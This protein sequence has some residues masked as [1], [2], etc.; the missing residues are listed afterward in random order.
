MPEG[1]EQPG[2]GRRRRRRRGG[3]GRRRGG[4]GRQQI[5]RVPLEPINLGE[6]LQSAPLSTYCRDCGAEVQGVL[7]GT[8]MQCPNCQGFNTAFGTELSVRNYFRL[9]ARPVKPRYD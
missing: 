5:Q 1:M 7:A 6:V 8:K 9:T 3:R 2:T 4:A